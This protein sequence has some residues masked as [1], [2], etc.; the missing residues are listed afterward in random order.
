MSEGLRREIAQQPHGT[1]QNKLIVIQ[2][3]MGQL[4]KITEEK[5]TRKEL[6][7]LDEIITDLIQNDVRGIS[8]Q[9]YPTV[10]RRGLRPALLSLFS[11]MEPAL[12]MDMQ[13]SENIQSRE[14]RE[15]DFISLTS[16]LAAYRIAED[17]LTNVIKHSETNAASIPLELDGEEHIRVTVKDEGVGFDSQLMPASLVL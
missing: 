15:R 17:A 14:A 13:F 16:R 3:I 10:L 7:K 5:S 2:Q 1:V 11:R 12:K 6:S 9:L 4:A 8:H